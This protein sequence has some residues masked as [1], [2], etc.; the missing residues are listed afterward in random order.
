MNMYLDN[1]KSLLDFKGVGQ[2]S[3][4]HGLS[5]MIT[6]CGYP[7]TVLS[8]EQGVT[9]LLL[10]LFLTRCLPIEVSFC[11]KHRCDVF[12][13]VRGVFRRD[14]RQFTLECAAQHARSQW[15]LRYFNLSRT[16]VQFSS[17]QFI[18]PM[19]QLK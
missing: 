14:T 18:D 16:S 4:S 11:V 7:R 5:C 10:L 12:P 3:R 13:T 2:R 15:K 6:Y 9:M 19:P 1:F 17:V 8:L